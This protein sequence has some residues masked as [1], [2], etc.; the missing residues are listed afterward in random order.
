PLCNLMKREGIKEGKTCYGL[1]SL[2]SEQ[3]RILRKEHKET[4][5]LYDN[6]II[7]NDLQDTWNE[8]VMYK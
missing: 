3:A 6:F 5:K 7:E 2:T 4:I 1:G 8:W